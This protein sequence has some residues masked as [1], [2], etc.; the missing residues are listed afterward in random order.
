MNSQSDSD[1]MDR[2]LIRFLLV[3]DDDDHAFLVERNL[4]RERVGNVLTRVKDGADALAYLRAE[5]PFEDRELPN[6]ILLDL[7]LP[8]LDGHEV[9]KVIKADPE[10]AKIPVVVMTTSDA[11]RDRAM[12]YELHV[13]SYLVKPLDFEQFRQM[14]RDLSLYWGVWNQPAN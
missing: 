3:E 8:K 6:V 12:A 10:L 1:P 9:L 2:D 14:V 7:R 4:D 13:N 5:A 11:E